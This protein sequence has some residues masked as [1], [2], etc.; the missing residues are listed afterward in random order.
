[1]ESA[2][3]T[4]FPFPHPFTRSNFHN[5]PRVQSLSHSR[6]RPA[7]QISRGMLSPEPHGI[8]RSIQTRPSQRSTFRNSSLPTAVTARTEFTTNNLTKWRIPNGT[9]ISGHGYLIVF[10]SGKNRT[11][12]FGKLHTN[13]Q[14]ANSGEYLALVNPQTNVISEFYPFF[15]SQQTDVSYG[16]DRVNPNIVGQFVVPTPGADNSFGTDPGLEVHFSRSG[17]TFAGSLVLELSTDDTNNIIRYNLISS[18]QD[19]NSATNIPTVTS[20]LYTNGVPLTITNTVQVRARAFP[21]NTNR[22]A[23]PPHTECYFLVNPGITNFVS[24]LPIVVIHTLSAT[25][26]SGGYPAFDNSVSIAVFDNDG[27]QASIMGTP[28]VVKRGGINLRGSSTQGLPK[29]SFAVEFWDQFNQDEE[30]SFAA[31][32]KESD[33]VLYA[34]NGFDKVLFHNP[35]MHQFGRDMGYYSSRTRFVEVFFRNGGG[36]ITATTN[37]TGGGM[38]DYYGVF[39]LE[40]KVK[41]D[42]NRVDLDALAPEQTNNPTITGGYLMK[43]DRTDGNERTF[44]AA[45]SGAGQGVTGVINYQDPDGL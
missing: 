30:P 12:I 15:P 20:T 27:G 6:P 17:G 39:V 31:L 41:R 40:E 32:P 1:M 19:V 26:I 2:R 38:G 29:S 22:F 16:R 28:Q 3:Q 4:S 7:S 35:I 18:A 45:G 25:A 11:N 8:T 23:G 43:I 14:L 5:R 33:W 42:G 21:A 9:S 13:F 44:N 36:A 24:P 10:A 37:S 34:C